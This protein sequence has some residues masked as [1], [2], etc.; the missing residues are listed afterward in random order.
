[1]ISCAVFPTS[2]V[3][4]L[5]DLLQGLF[6]RQAITELSTSVHVLSDS[7]WV[8]IESSSTSSA[9]KLYKSKVA[10]YFF[11]AEKE[12]RATI[13]ACVGNFVQKCC[14]TR[15]L[16]QPRKRTRRKTPSRSGGVVSTRSETGTAGED[17]SKLSDKRRHG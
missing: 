10:L 6:A 16:A 14:F 17:K 9:L 8:S 2:D 3:S 7:R 11:L 15:S 1:M 12:Q 13:G 4:V 5:E